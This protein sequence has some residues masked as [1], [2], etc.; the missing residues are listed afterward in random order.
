MAHLMRRLASI[1]AAYMSTIA[2]A[3][4]GTTTVTPTFHPPTG[5]PKPDRVLLFD[6]AVTPAEAGI[7]SGIGSLTQTQED[8]RVGKAFAQALSI[9]LVKELRNRGIDAY[10]ANETAPPGET[11]AS[12]K[13]KFLRDDR[14]T[15][16][17]ST[18]VGFAL[19]GSQVRTLIQILQG[20]GLKLQLVG[21]AETATPSNLSAGSGANAVEADAA[22]TAQAVAERI[23]GYYKKQGWINP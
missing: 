17:T 14:G 10:R 15:S 1:A 4:C 22:R 13:G 5:L 18:P 7:D 11:S 19:S 9:N 23:V 2:L 16:T 6:F 20:T 8:V 12:I 21:E 3:G